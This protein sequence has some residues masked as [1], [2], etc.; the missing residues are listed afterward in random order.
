MTG[1]DQKQAEPDT[2]KQSKNKKR[3]STYSYTCTSHH[4]MPGVFHKGQRGVETS[5]GVA[6]RKRPFS[7]ALSRSYYQYMGQGLAWGWVLFLRKNIIIRIHSSSEIPG[8]L[9]NTTRE[10]ARYRKYTSYCKKYQQIARGGSV[11]VLNTNSNAVVT[12]SRHECFGCEL[13]LKSVRRHLCGDRS[14]TCFQLRSR[15]GRRPSR[16]A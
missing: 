1:D 16:E 8:S 4:T 2:S 9:P 13:Q 11:S 5:V 14:F 10:G 6:R 7:V 3:S 12:P 15:Y